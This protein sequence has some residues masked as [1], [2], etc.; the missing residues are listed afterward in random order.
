MPS[1]PVL[2]VTLAGPQRGTSSRAYEVHV[3]AVVQTRATLDVATGAYHNRYFVQYSVSVDAVGPSGTLDLFDNHTGDCFARLINVDGSAIIVRL[4]LRALSVNP[5][6]LVTLEDAN[7]LVQPLAVG[8][9]FLA[10]A[11]VRKLG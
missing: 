11:G 6:R 1:V 2:K 8:I 5:P 4:P 10:A 7:Q 3:G 9:L